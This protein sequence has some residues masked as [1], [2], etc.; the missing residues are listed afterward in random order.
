M[1][2]YSK[3]EINNI[4]NRISHF[5]IQFLDLFSFNKR[6]EFNFKNL[7]SFFYNFSSIKLYIVAKV[8]VN[9]I[10]LILFFMI[11][12]IVNWLL[13]KRFFGIKDE[14][15]NKL[16]FDFRKSYFFSKFLMLSITLLVISA[17]IT[18]FKIL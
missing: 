14:K 15:S 17:I 8:L 9:N 6:L 10:V 16:F 7:T 1:G 3:C 13:Q 4:N 5:I 2:I 18:T 11:Y 12:C